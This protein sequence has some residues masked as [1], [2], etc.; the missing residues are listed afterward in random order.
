ME[1]LSRVQTTQPAL[2]V[3]QVSTDQGQGSRANRKRSQKQR[4]RNKSN[5]GVVQIAKME[6]IG[7]RSA[8][9][10]LDLRYDQSSLTKLQS[11]KQKQHQLQLKKPVSLVNPV[12]RV[13][14]GD[15]I[16]KQQ[17]LASL[18]LCD[19]LTLMNVLTCGVLLLHRFNR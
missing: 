16:F 3:A 15:A 12:R 8:L 18:S 4:K 14:V 9:R 2:R 7:I 17:G 6:G 13:E 5:A 1:T 10:T 11:K 19:S